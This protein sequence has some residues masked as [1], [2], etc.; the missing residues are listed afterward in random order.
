M[1]LIPSPSVGQMLASFSAM[2][3]LS[4]GKEEESLVTTPSTKR[5]IRQFHVLV[6]QG[7]QRSVRKSTCKVVV[8]PIQ[9]YCCCF[10]F[11]RSRYR[12]R[13]RCLTSL[14]VLF[15]D[16]VFVTGRSRLVLVSLKD[17]SLLASHSIPCEPLSP[18]AHG[19]FTNDG[20][21]DFVVHC[22]A[23]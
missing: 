5:A 19:D 21:M 20:L 18:V 15:Q 7:R 8:L 14:F 22:R 3:L 23:R 1:S 9:T 16:A 11:C 12:H 2:E 6:G 17:G 10:F 4:S 13:C